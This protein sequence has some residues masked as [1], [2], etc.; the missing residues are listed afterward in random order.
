MMP[1]DI[2]RPPGNPSGPM[3][4]KPVLDESLIIPQVVIDQA[5]GKDV[6]IGYDVKTLLG[7][8]DTD[9]ELSGIITSDLLSGV[10]WG[11]IPL[12]PHKVRRWVDNHNRLVKRIA[13]QRRDGS[14]YGKYTFVEE[15]E[16]QALLSEDEQFWLSSLLEVDLTLYE[17][18]RREHIARL[19]AGIGEVAGLIE[20]KRSK[21]K[22]RR[23][24]KR[25]KAKQEVI[26]AELAD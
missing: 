6:V 21:P 1:Q 9:R 10:E 18:M 16:W 12:Q 25:K 19:M 23:K 14:V 7:L 11:V 15:R 4:N 3:K 24:G 5:T 2:V 20:E 8:R 17:E 22:V 13:R 26:Y